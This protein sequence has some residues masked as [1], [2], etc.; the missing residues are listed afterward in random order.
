MQGR[1][2]NLSINRNK[3][4]LENLKKVKKEIQNSF[5]TPIP[6]PPEIIDIAAYEKA[7]E[8]EK[9]KSLSE[10]VSESLNVN[11][12]GNVQM[13]E[14]TNKH[15]R[16]LAIFSGVK[17][18]YSKKDYERMVDDLSSEAFRDNWIELAKDKT[19]KE[20]K[21]FLSWVY[22]NI[23]K[24]EIK[25]DLNNLKDCPKLKFIGAYFK[26]AYPELKGQHP[27]F[28]P[29]GTNLT[30]IDSQEETLK[31]RLKT[32][33]SNH[34]II[35]EQKLIQA[36]KLNELNIEKYNRR[37]EAFDSGYK[38]YKKAMDENKEMRVKTKKDLNSEILETDLL[39][40]DLKILDD[41]YKFE[42]TVQV[43][44]VRHK[45]WEDDK[46]CI[47]IETIKKEKPIIEY[48]NKILKSLEKRASD[49]KH[50]M[51]I[52]DV[53]EGNYRI[54][55]HDFLEDVYAHEDIDNFLTKIE[56][57]KAKY[58]KY[59]FRMKSINHRFDVVQFVH[60]IINHIYV[61]DINRKYKYENS[62]AKLILLGYDIRMIHP[63]LNAPKIINFLRN[64]SHLE[65]SLISEKLS[66]YCFELYIKEKS[67]RVAAKLM[68]SKKTTNI[69]AQIDKMHRKTGERLSVENYKEYR[70]DKNLNDRRVKKVKN[71]IYHYLYNDKM[72]NTKS[73]NIIKTDLAVHYKKAGS[74]APRPT[75]ISYDV[76]WDA[77]KAARINFQK[78]ALMKQ[79][80]MR[81][82]ITGEHF[83]IEK[84]KIKYYTKKK[85]R[86]TIEITTNG[87]TNIVPQRTCDELK[88]KGLITG[89]FTYTAMLNQIGTNKMVQLMSRM[90][91]NTE[92]YFSVK[93]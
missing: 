58:D 6:E 27:F 59:N 44:E 60:N 16:T 8:I 14:N 80:Q 2:F 29:G 61:K 53:H 48:N 79:A 22:N 73:E 24:E 68:R 7:L 69:N 20:M 17:A 72:V 32:T 86:R 46:P 21:A 37:K 43:K 33:T 87:F 34:Q 54:L 4:I 15:I 51:G 70:K 85:Y 92:S 56:L 25:D 45:Y 74:G 65:P 38:A 36:K 78:N 42:D 41:Y 62:W 1:K 9:N 63:R 39:E 67:L 75:N 93:S 18:P 50:Y 10:K 3:E 91:V 11:Q 13:T 31:A 40:V 12:F 23:L 30:S 76:K 83:N 82:E 88:L 64:N 90:S 47:R 19:N 5:R 89:N 81:I 55:L 26:R 28:T 57:Y 49:E 71:S 35:L 66:Q 52:V 77:A 84:G